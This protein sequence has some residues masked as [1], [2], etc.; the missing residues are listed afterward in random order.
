[1]AKKQTTRVL[2]V[3]A[4]KGGVGKSTLSAALAVR[5]SKEGRVA[6]IDADEQSSLRDW[7]TWR[8]K[9]NNPQLLEMDCEPEALEL[10]YAE[11][12]DW[13]IIDTPPA[14]IRAITNAVQLADLVL[15]PTRPSPLDLEALKVTLAITEQQKKPHVFILNQADAA[16]KLTSTVASTLKET[17]DLLTPFI[18][19]RPAYVRAM[20][21]GR[22]GPEIAGGGA[23]ATEI[24][25]LWES[26]K[27][28]VAQGGRSK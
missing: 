15:I 14:I 8:G 16:S 11:G 28:R 4:S 2:A 20:I 25:A 13:L 10:I 5:A 19:Q 22:T 9:P 21:T 23:C 3:A 12:F 6:I 1:M 7:W 24:D 27:R 26:V 17:G 18:A